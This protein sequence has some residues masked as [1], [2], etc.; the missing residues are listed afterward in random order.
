M[1]I[2]LEQA[3]QRIRDLLN[4]LLETDAEL[5]NVNSRLEETQRTVGLLHSMLLLLTGQ[6]VHFD[7]VERALTAVILLVM[8]GF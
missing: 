5:Y 1:R 3:H 2:E 6:P 4:Q 7:S 8:L